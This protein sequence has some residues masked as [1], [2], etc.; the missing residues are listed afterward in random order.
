MSLDI[1][2]GERTPIREF[3]STSM[4]QASWSGGLANRAERTWGQ[5]LTI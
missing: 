1:Y 3:I 4:N 2:R 5:E